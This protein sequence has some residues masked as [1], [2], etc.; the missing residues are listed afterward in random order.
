[1]I[2]YRAFL[3]LIANYNGLTPIAIILDY[4]ISFTEFSQRPGK[5][6]YPF[7]HLVTECSLP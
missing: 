6:N 5:Q 2:G 3:M 4:V 1:M 7:K